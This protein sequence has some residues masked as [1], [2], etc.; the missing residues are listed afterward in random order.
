MFQFRSPN[1][2]RILIRGI[3]T[4]VVGII[5]VVVPGFS[6]NTVIQF[7]GGVLIFDGLINLIPAM[8]KKSK[9]QNMFIVVPRGTTNI[10]VGVILLLFPQLVVGVFFFLIGFILI[11]AGGSQLAAQL[12]GRS[13]LGFSW[14]ISIFSFIALGAGAF[15]LFFPK[16]IGDAMFLFIGIVIALYGIG[17]IVWSFRIRKYQKQHIPEEPGVIDAEYEEVE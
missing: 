4:A 13:V 10:I 14:L 6:I 5:I 2:T 16:K 9:Q 3:F 11:V 8:I 15:M 17:E 1:P 7:L 12:G